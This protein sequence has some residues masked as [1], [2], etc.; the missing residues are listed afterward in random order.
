MVHGFLS[1]RTHGFIAVSEAS[2]QAMIARGDA[3]GERLSLVPNGIDD[4]LP[5]ADSIR[6]Q[7][8]VP[9]TSPLV[10][11]AARLEPEKDIASL[12]RAFSRVVEVHPAAV[13]L[14]A[15]EGTQEASLRRLIDE[16]KLGDVCKLLGFRED[17]LRVMQAAD[18]FALPSPAEPFGLVLLEA[19]ALHKPIVAVNAGGPAEIVTHNETGILV[20]PSDPQSLAA[21]LIRLLNDSSARLEM[22]RAG[23]LRWL[24]RYT[25]DR[26]AAETLA[27]YDRALAVPA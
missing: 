15:G 10:V 21:A 18:V 2:R 14:I 12:I 7:L 26:M 1:R 24:S 23:R 27:G 9:P 3:P 16:L 4:P 6:E 20:P 17:V 13:C 8:G 11:C 5:P 22:G 25:A 19:M